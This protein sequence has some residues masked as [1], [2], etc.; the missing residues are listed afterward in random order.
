MI[1]FM[2]VFACTFG[3]CETLQERIDATAA[4]GGGVVCVEPGEHLLRGPVH[5]RSNI[6]LNLAE[7]AKLVNLR[8]DKRLPIDGVTLEDVRAEKIRRSKFWASQGFRRRQR[9]R[10]GI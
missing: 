10:E 2:L 6:E 4:A 3:R 8:G 9:E 7:G 5:L 1:A